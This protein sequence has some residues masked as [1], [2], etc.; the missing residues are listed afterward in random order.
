MGKRDSLGMIFPYYSFKTS[1]ANHPQNCLAKEV[2]IMGYNI[3][4]H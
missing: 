2:L 1:V 4:F 3:H